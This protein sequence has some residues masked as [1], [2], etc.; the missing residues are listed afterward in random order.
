[1][2]RRTEMAVREEIRKIPDGVYNGASATDDDGTTLDEPVWVR[3]RITVKGDEMTI[4]LSESDAQRK[5]L[6]Q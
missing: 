3:A 4:D 1:M 2:L 6:R 5:G